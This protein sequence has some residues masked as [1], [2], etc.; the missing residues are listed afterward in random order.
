[1]KRL[2]EKLKLMFARQPHLPQTNVSGSACSYCNG[3]GKI[4]NW[5]F[6]Q[7]VRCGVCQ[8][9]RVL[10]RYRMRHITKNDMKMLSAM[11]LIAVA[12]ITA[13]I[14]LFTTNQ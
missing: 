3:N 7:F 10:A 12:I 11:F 1:M 14:L 9:D 2:I 5:E 13:F 8:A 6:G 4:F